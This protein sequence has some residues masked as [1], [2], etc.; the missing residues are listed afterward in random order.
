MS[1][2][3]VITPKPLE[4]TDRVVA[5]IQYLDGTIIDTIKQVKD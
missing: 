4:Y 5:L 2:K 3:H 1:Q